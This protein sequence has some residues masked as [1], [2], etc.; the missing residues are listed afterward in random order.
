VAPETPPGTAG[1]RPS[2]RLN[3]D[4]AWAVI[5]DSHT[6]ILTTLRRDGT[7]ITLPTWFVDLDRTVCFSTPA[8]TKKVGRIR[9]NSRVS[10]LVE[11]G[12]RWAELQAVHLT[13]VAEVVDDPQLAARIAAALDSK[14]EAF[15]TRRAAMPAAT[16]D[17]YESHGTVYIRILP[18]DRILNW[19]NS[20][21]GLG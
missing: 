3:R 15:R 16:R 8:L 21:L 19:D 12:R 20:R 7:P 6:G 18:D 5:H 17:H 11:S 4:E 13:G 10:F 9:R 2:V 1:R 14:Y